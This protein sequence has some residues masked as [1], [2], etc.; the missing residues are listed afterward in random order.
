[1]KKQIL[2]TALFFLFSASVAAQDFYLHENG[3]TVKCENAEVGDTGEVNGVTYTKRSRDQITTENA[4]TTCTSGIVDM[5]R[6]FQASLFNEDISS[7]DVSSV[8]TMFEMFRNAWGFD[9]PIGNWDVSSVTNMGWMFS[10]ADVFDQFIGNWDVSSVTNMNRMF[11]LAGSFNQPIGDWDVSNV[12]DMRFMFS[13]ATSFDQPIGNWDVGNVTTLQGLFQCFNC[14]SIFNQDLSNWDVSNVTDMSFMFENN[15]AFDQPIGNW[16]VA[17]VTSMLHLFTNA[18][19]FNQD[20]GNW[21][22]SSVTDMNSM[23]SNATSF[24]QDLS[25][26]CVENIPAVPHGFSFNSPLAE[27]NKPVWGTCPDATSI[28][29]EGIP[30]VFSLGQNYPNPFNPS[31]VIEYQLPV[32]SEVSIE[33]YN[34]LGR[35]VATLVNER[36][37]AG[38]HNVTFDASGLSS[39][40]YVYRIRSGEFVQTRKM[41]L[42]K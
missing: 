18:Q 42:V 16:N 39:G 32:N 22:V 17:S 33:V 2:S 28:E 12:T 10:N 15:I 7:W 40:V 19:A 23:F 6:L 1:M 27:D 20:I 14:E 4:A 29:A 38:H 24:N 41:M 21:D 35:R 26:W 5:S 34:L 13:N 25:L 31:T 3:V 30:I 37:P 36:K 9:Q 8:T 11:L